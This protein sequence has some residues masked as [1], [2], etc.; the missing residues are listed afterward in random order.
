[1]RGWC[2]QA[3]VRQRH[4]VTPEGSVD[5]NGSAV[6]AD[7]VLMRFLSP[8]FLQLVSASRI[9]VSSPPCS[10]TCCSE[11]VRPRVVRSLTVVTREFKDQMPG[12]LELESRLPLAAMI[13][14]LSD[15][16]VYVCLIL[17]SV[18]PVFDVATPAGLIK[19]EYIHDCIQMDLPPGMPLSDHQ[20][21][22]KLPPPDHYGQALP[23]PQMSAEPHGPPPVNRCAN[24][25]ISPKG[26]L[27]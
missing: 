13:H 4:A 5:P 8:C 24:L 26:R 25:P 3:S 14:M 9:L 17:S 20:T 7:A 21:S 23:P 12:R 18:L 22:L 27:L 11:R 6:T 16:G 2:R 10:A 15:G 19:E 1:M